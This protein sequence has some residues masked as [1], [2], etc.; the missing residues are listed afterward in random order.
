MFT[1]FPPGV[2]ARRRRAA[3]ARLTGTY[4]EAMVIGNVDVSVE[5][6]SIE[7]VEDALGVKLQTDAW[8][9]NFRAAPDE[10]A[11]LEGVRRADWAARRSIQAGRA[12]GSLVYWASDGDTVSLLVGADDETWDIAVFFPVSVVGEI[13]RQAEAEDQHGG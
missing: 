4:P 12:C 8:E 10:L 6:V 5:Y 9:V 3:A 2:T 7:D 13:L 1:R 11:K